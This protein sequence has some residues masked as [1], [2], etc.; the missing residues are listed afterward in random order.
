MLAVS[1][2]CF[3]WQV[4]HKTKTLPVTLLY[5]ERVVN[6]ISYSKRTQ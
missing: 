3:I 1:S 6:D 4:M 5:Q 2:T